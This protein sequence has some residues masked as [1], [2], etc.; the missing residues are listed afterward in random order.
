MFTEV[1]NYIDIT[2]HKANAKKKLTTIAM[3]QDKTVSKFYYQI[4]D[5]W[6]ITG[7][8]SEDQIKIF[9]A[10]LLP[11]ICNQISMKRY[12]NFSTLL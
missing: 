9:Q 8:Q 10:L 4:F 1:E 7:T 12:T 2:Q 5:L 3:K 6:I 11:W